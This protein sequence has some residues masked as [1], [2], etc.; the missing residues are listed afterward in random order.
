MPRFQLLIREPGKPPRV[1]ALGAPLLFGRSRRA[2]VTVDDEEVG[3]EQF[4]I[5]VD[6]E[7]VFLE[8][9]GKT[10]RTALDGTTVGPGQRTTAKVGAVIQVGRTTF[11]LQ[12]VQSSTPPLPAVEV[13]E[14]TMVAPSRSAAPAPTPPPAELPPEDRTGGYTGPM[15][16][17]ELQRPGQ[18]PPPPTPPTES[19]PPGRAPG[20]PDSSMTMAPR[21]YRPGQAAAPVDPGRTAPPVP[22]GRTPP[23]APAEDAGGMTIPLRGY[24]PGQAAAPT[25][26]PA[27]ATPARTPAPPPAQPAAP[28]QP[29]PP[30]PPVAATPAPDTPAAKGRTMVVAAGGGAGPAGSAAG[31]DVEARLH[32]TLP[33]LFVKGE[34]LKRRLRLMKVQNRIGRAE[35]SDVLLPHDSVSELH[36]EIR[37][38][39]TGWRLRD[40]GSTNGTLVDGKLVRG[41]EQAI[42]RHTL[43]GFGNLR[44]IFL[45]NDATTAAADRRL[46]ERAVQRLVKQARLGRD[47][48]KQAVQLAREDQSQSL[49]ELLL[50]DTPITPVDW[51]DAITA[52]RGS[53]G[54]L[55][56]LL[57]LFRGRKK[58]LPPLQ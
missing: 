51:H 13:A 29:P 20:V 44:A 11:E 21:A 3:R 54:L 8:G 46:E 37:F 40:A 52:A 47:V 23:P 32:Q 56:R 33:R 53:G 7:A 14:A 25:P 48:A 43:L 28:P 10:N 16:T 9:I 30:P 57:G 39:G 17:M 38:D 42:G 2:D 12:L 18:P 1:V 27:A 26:A 6:G 50:T 22:P 4:R 5:G 45:C 35:T 58:P 31:A 15:H 19:L 36:A 34:T 41:E 49:A 24:R 55:A